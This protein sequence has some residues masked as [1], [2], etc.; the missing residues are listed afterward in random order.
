MFSRS[1][2]VETF[3]LSSERIFVSIS[4]CTEFNLKFIKAK[5]FT[6]FTSEK[7]QKNIWNWSAHVWV[8]SSTP[9][10][11]ISL[12]I[13][14]NASAICVSDS[15]KFETILKYKSAKILIRWTSSNSMLSDHSLNNDTHDKF[16]T[17]VSITTSNS[18][19]SETWWSIEPPLDSI[20]IRLKQYWKHLLEIA[21]ISPAKKCKKK[22]IE[23]N[24]QMWCNYY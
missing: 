8:H 13:E 15:W 19:S 22:Q 14:P 18:R 16:S 2:C 7:M 10:I 12:S 11:T 5:Y 4:G 20:V 3:I 24:C 17:F 1:V 9:F 23:H 6:D 21:P